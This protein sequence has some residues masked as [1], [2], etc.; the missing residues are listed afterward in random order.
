MISFQNPQ[1]LVILIFMLVPVIKAFRLNGL[2]QKIGFLNVFTAFILVI[3]A[4]GP[5]L[6][7]ES[8]E[9]PRPSVTVIEDSSE[10][11]QLIQEIDFESENV[12]LER[13]TVNSDAENFESQMKNAVETGGKYLFVSDLNFDT[14]LPSYFAEENVSMNL[15]RAD[16]VSESS[17]RIEGP[18]ETVI[19]AENRYTVYTEST[20]GEDPEIEV[21]LNNQTI[22]TGESPLQ[23]NLSFEQKGYQ[24]LSAEISSSD[25]YP[26]N[27]EFYKAINVQEKPEI[28]SIGA[29][30]GLED[31]FS[32]FYQIDSY[33][34]IP[35]NLENYQAVI[36]KQG[37]D[38][39]QLRSYLEQGG[40]LM[41]T[42][43]DYS[44]EYLPVRSA[45]RSENTDAPL[46][47]ILMDISQSTGCQ[48]E[49]EETTICTYEGDEAAT[50]LSV[51]VG[52]EIIEG[53]PANARVSLVPY[54]EWPHYTQLNDP[55]L[56]GSSK[57]QILD[58]ISRI[59]P[60]NEPTY[61]EQGLRRAGSILSDYSGQGNVVMITN[62]RIPVIAGERSREAAQ[63][64][65]STLDSRLITVGV[66]EQFA[67]PE[68]EDEEFLQ[69]LAE[70]T[71]GGFY[72]DAQSTDTL[73]FTFEAGGG[74]G[75]VQPLVVS[76]SN[77]FITSNYEPQARLS[78]IDGTETRP[79][80]N[81]LVSTSDGSP[82]LSTTRYGLGR[83]AAF[84]ADNSDLD[85]LMDQDPSLVGRTM[86][87]TSG[88]IE[89]DLRVE[90]SRLGDEFRLI[91]TEERQNFTRR[92][93][94]RF[95][96][97]LNPSETGFQREE[98]LTYSVNYRPEIEHVGYNEEKFTEF[99]VSGNVYEPG[100]LS[101][102][103]SD[104]EPEPERVED[105]LDLR[106][107]LLGLGVIAYLSFVGLRKRNGLA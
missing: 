27:N 28:A 105:N 22:E 26:T 76:N 103:Y 82:V 38:S 65:A 94:Q 74:S 23:L 61:H 39:Q 24:E 34:S 55:R 86:S 71:E 42:G 35:S 68:E 83:V 5:V 77:H 75:E 3:A 89:K 69:G 79:V 19:G 37:Q 67:P 59:R 54:A 18:S 100:G 80:G 29:N 45:E 73:N 106:P 90:G 32:E 16:M 99:T 31:Q 43:G 25:R 9:D 52:S 20:E 41:Y 40:G 58:D 4:S 46:V 47:V 30:S 17:V 53:L 101:E 7:M 85:T 84:S 66:A 57:D 48:S 78:E 49:E 97:E 70:R 56:L 12:N 13:R 88:P 96:R 95:I 11:S 60:E 2:K 33:D 102:F 87:W 81:Q 8:M 14:D 64:E 91:S 50:P 93:S 6:T 62:G 92:S 15:L 98:N 51:I 10:S 104:L 36:M 21:S 107:Y 63:N 72:I 44:L 1:I